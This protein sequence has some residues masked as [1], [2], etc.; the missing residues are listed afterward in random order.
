[1][2][3]GFRVTYDIVT[4]ESAEHGDYAEI[5]YV[6]PGGWH[7]DIETVMANRDREPIGSYDMSLGEA[8]SLI[9]CVEHDGH[10]YSETDGRV[11]YKTGA[12][13]RYTLHLPENITNASRKRVHRLLKSERRI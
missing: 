5:G 3:K 7:Y 12:E 9:G 4:P 6:L 13:T 11:D 10:C 8:L 2:R 1:M